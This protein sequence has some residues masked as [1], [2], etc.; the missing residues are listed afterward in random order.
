MPAVF[1][2]Q[3][4]S[5]EWAIRVWML[6]LS[7][8]SLAA[9]W[10]VAEKSLRV[11]LAVTLVLL[12]LFAYPMHFAQREQ[13]AFLLCA[14]YV[15]GSSRCRSWG[16]LSGVMGG[17][18]F[19]IKPHFL[20]PLVLICALRRN[21]GIQERAIVVV[22]IIYG[23]ILVLFFQ[24]Y[25]FNMVPA[26]MATYWAISYPW[27]DSAQQALFI[28]LCSLPLVMAGAMPL[29]ARPYLVATFGFTVAAVLQGKGFIYHFIPAFCFLAMFLVVC[30][31]NP[32]RFFARISMLL[33]IMQIALLSKITGYW[34]YGTQQ[35]AE[36]YLA[37]R[38]E[39]D[40]SG[41][42]ASLHPNPSLVFPW[43]IHSPSEFKGVAICQI[44]LPAVRKHIAGQGK[45]SPEVAYQLALEQAKTELRRRPNLVFVSRLDHDGTPFDYLPWLL[46]DP[47]FSKLWTNYQF[48]RSIGPFRLFRLK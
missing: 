19:L 34:I 14:P 29:A 42:Y 47:E 41:S 36:G 30:S 24:P 23:F 8:L 38:Q 40:Q 39:I 1:L 21:F 6:L 5:F 7:L 15:A 31:M 33:L 32:N 26:A 11:P 13:I 4:M 3:L 10:A 48:Y 27:T 16:L 9:F 28:L 45:G 22:G 2:A 17:V 44:F 37:I 20:I 18:G 25:M 35:N 43:A 12:L 46:Q